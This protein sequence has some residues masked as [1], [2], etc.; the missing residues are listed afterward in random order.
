MQ[1]DDIYINKAE[2][3]AVVGE[4]KIELTPIQFRLLWTLMLYQGEVL[5]KAFLYQ[6]VLNRALGQHDRVL[7]MHLSR[8]RRKIIAVGGAG[9]RLQTV[10]GE[11]YCIS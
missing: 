6:P 5:S 10:H 3:V 4:Q 2:G 9:E 11:G 7:D 8:V 1:I